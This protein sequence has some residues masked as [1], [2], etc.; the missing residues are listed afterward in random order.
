MAIENGDQVTIEYVGQLNDG[1][2]FDT[3]RESIAEES[4]LREAQ[5][6]REYTPLTVRIGDEEIIEGLEDGLIGLQ[7]S[8]T[9]TITIPPEKAYGE[10]SDD[11]IIEQDRDNFEEVLQGETPEEGMMIQEQDGGIGKVIHVGSEIVRLDF[12]HELAGETLEFEVE[13][14]D[15]S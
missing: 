1:T 6:E 13:I 4:G 10:P 2:V 12:N 9:E 14:V 7:E 15:V 3:S 8:D 5:P 11:Q